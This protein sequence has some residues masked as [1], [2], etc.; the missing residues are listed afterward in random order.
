MAAPRRQVDAAQLISP[1]L[2]ASELAITRLFA[3]ARAATPCIL[4]LDGLEVLAARRNYTCGFVGK[5]HLGFPL[6]Q[7]RPG[8]RAQFVGGARG[9]RLRAAADVEVM[10][11]CRI[12]I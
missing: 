8:A 9:V 4:F 3:A 12:S 7:K 10:S 2:G 11:E 5:Y 1:S 6:P